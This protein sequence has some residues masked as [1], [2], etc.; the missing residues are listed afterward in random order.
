MAQIIYLVSEKKIIKNFR[1][2]KK[3]RK[4]SPTKN[5]DIKPEILERVKNFELDRK[6][7][8]SN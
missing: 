4:F 1:L 2:R 5:F 7:Q 6:I 3:K 8:F